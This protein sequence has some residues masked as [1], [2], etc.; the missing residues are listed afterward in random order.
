MKRLFIYQILILFL[1]FTACHNE[2]DDNTE[3]NSND[4]PNQDVYCYETCDTQSLKQCVSGNVSVCE[5]DENGCAHW[6][7]SEICASDTVCDATSLACKTRTDTQT[8][9]KIRFMAGNI[10]SG[11][12]QTYDF[13]HGNRIFQAMAPDIVMIQEFNIKS[14]TRE[15]FVAAVF[16][17]D[18]T[19]S[20]SDNNIPN[21]IIS[22]YPIVSSGFWES[23][24]ASSRN[25]DWAVIDIPGDTDLLAVS[26]HLHTKNNPEEIPVL[27]QKIQEKQAEGNYYVV[28][29][30]DF[31]TS[32]RD[33]VLKNM[34]SVFNVRGPWPIDQN[35]REGTDENRN[36]KPLTS[37]RPLDWLLFSQNLD[38]YEIPIQIGKHTYADGHILD[39]RVYA[40][41][42]EVHAHENELADI[43]P[44]EA[45][46]SDAEAMQHM[47]VIRDVMIPVEN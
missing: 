47:A 35:G 41:L 36:E 7:V 14:K 28:I 32:K 9:Q 43:P 2:N 38:V 4:T 25:W 10:T 15:Q 16:G 1:T 46:D 22:R 20:M 21:G 44:V 26:V 45:G 33:D 5:T 31:N 40:G 27:T 37:Q 29:G 11:T 23:N 30:G 18:F 24:I 3:T 6:Q 12:Y 39:S 19:F 8:R 17:E 13:G 42:C 34:G